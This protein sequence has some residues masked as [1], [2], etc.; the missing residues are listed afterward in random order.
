MPRSVIIT[1]A[2]TSNDVDDSFGK[3]RVSSKMTSGKSLAMK[4]LPS[5]SAVVIV[6]M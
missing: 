4:A 2:M 5:L 1:D 6:F 3:S